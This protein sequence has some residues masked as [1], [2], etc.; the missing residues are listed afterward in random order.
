[1]KVNIHARKKRHESIAFNSKHKIHST[2]NSKVYYQF[3]IKICF[4]SFLFVLLY[5]VSIYQLVEA[6]SLDVNNVIE[7]PEISGT[8]VYVLGS[9]GFVLKPIIQTS[10][11]D[12]S[13]SNEI[14]EYIIEPGDTLIGIAAKLSVTSQT[15]IDN[16][17]Q[18]KNFSH[19]GIGNT[20]RI[21]PVDGLIYNV[22]S[23]DSVQSI[24][25]KFK[26]SSEKIIKQN[27]IQLTD[28]NLPEVLIIP[29]AKKYYN[30]TRKKYAKYTFTP[31]GNV[32]FI[33]PTGGDITQYYRRGHY[34][35]DIGNRKKGPIY[36]VAGGTVKNASYGWNGGYGNMVLI[37]HGNNLK[38]LYAHN[39]KLY[40]SVGEKV[41]QGQTIAWMGNTG[42]VRGATGI[43][44][45]FEIIH[46]G[47]KKNPLAYLK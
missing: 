39:E 24:A 2:K 35:L 27:K 33:W 31:V 19:L 36:A 32:S 9:D 12:R 1:M 18:V 6:Y 42:R 37:D 4:S 38:T 46:N 28:T 43:H 25:K 15:I 44:L 16:N 41:T 20:L 10:K 8:E 21:P 40:V 5:F 3:I 47:I 29:G 30:S 14:L 34:A 11:S 26:I 7:T 13:E 23:K 45:H 17:S 22:N